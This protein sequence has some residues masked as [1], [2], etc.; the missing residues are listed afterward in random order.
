MQR[1]SFTVTRRVGEKSVCYDANHLAIVRGYDPDLGPGSISLL[2]FV[3]SGVQTTFPAREIERVTFH[4]TSA[5]HCSECDGSIYNYVGE[6]I[7]ANPVVVEGIP[8]SN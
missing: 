4:P 6:G 3:C 2:T 5:Q 8:V 1:A 7:H